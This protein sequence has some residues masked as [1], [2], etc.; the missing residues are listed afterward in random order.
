MSPSWGREISDRLLDGQT[1]RSSARTAL[2]AGGCMPSTVTPNT[3]TSTSPRPL[4][5]SRGYPAVLRTED[6]AVPRARASERAIEQ[7]RAGPGFNRLAITVTVAPL[8]D[9]AGGSFA[10]PSAMSLVSGTS[11][12]VVQEVSPKSDHD[13][14]ALYCSLLDG[15]SVLTKRPRLTASEPEEEVQK[16]GVKLLLNQHVGA[17]IRNPSAASGITLPT[18]MGSKLSILN[19]HPQQLL[20]VVFSR[21]SVSLHW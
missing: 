10:V 17:A 13:G 4:H 9:P 15:D 5:G 19:Y 7:R 16:D 8:V 2:L 18:A 21:S 12:P 11:A 6:G 14:S 1:M 20:G 3:P